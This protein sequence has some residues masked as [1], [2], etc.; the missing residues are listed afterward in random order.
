MLVC[1][2]F[3]IG[4]DKPL[5]IGDKP[6]EFLLYDLNDKLVSLYQSKGKVVVLYFWADGCCKDRTLLADEDFYKKYKEKGLV[7]LAINSG[8][9][10]KVVEKF[11][12]ERN[13]P[14]LVLLDLRFSATKQYGVTAL[15]MIFVLD[16]EGTIR[17]RVLGQVEF[18]YLEKVLDPLL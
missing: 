11:A 18:A 1:V 2:I 17:N 4:F 13:L 10:K 6:P 3:L 14:Y 16:R 15:P 7:I 5:K 12:R 8:Q 9:P